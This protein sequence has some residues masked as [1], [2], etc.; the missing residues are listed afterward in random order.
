MQRDKVHQVLRFASKNL[1]PE[2][3]REQMLA[4]MQLKFKT[5]EL[6]QEEIIAD[7]P[8]AVRSSIAQHLFQRTVKST[9]LFKGI[10]PD[11]IAQLVRIFHRYILF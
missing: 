9:Y 5:M 6:Q 4:H 1:L 2:G 8:K 3:L 7:L 10:S 11:F